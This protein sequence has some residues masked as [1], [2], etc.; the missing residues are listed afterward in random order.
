[1]GLMYKDEVTLAGLLLLGKKE[2]LVHHVPQHEVT[3]LR[4]RSSTR[5]DQRRT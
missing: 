2:S 1:M 5:Y 4:Y 3:F